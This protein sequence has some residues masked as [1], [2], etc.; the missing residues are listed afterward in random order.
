V[1]NKP[2]KGFSLP[3]S[4][5]F[6]GELRHRVDALLQ[7]GVRIAEYVD[8]A[9]VRRL[10][11]EHQSGRRDHGSQLWRLLALE[12]WLEFLDRGE[13]SQPSHGRIDD[14]VVAMA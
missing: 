6:R 13:L 4:G 8:P 12:L 3:I 10:A 14:A 1:L 2:K 9:A 7:P 5:W 11:A